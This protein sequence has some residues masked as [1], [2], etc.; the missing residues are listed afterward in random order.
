MKN[1][2]TSARFQIL[3]IRKCEIIIIIEGFSGL[4]LRNVI[5]KY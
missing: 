1:S 3:K 4:K 5:L 2:M